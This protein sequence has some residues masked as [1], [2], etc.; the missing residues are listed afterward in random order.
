M[1]SE[2]RGTCRWLLQVCPMRRGHDEYPAAGVELAHVGER[3]LGD[4]AL[5]V[6]GALD[7]V[8]VH[9][10]EMTVGRTANVQLDA[11]AQVEAGGEA[12]Q[13]VLRGVFEEAAMADDAHFAGGA[14]FGTSD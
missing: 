12:R 11:E 8:V 10:D 4:L 13:R 2:S 9:T 1:V 3:H 7:V 6:G 14:L 5:A